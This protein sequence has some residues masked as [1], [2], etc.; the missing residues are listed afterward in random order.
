MKNSSNVFDWKAQPSAIARAI[1]DSRHTTPKA[2]GRAMTQRRYS[3]PIEGRAAAQQAVD[4]RAALVRGR[5]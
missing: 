2:L 1:S 5:I 4:K 3:P